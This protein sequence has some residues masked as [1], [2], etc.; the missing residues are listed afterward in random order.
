M[1]IY[2][3]QMCYYR[4]NLLSEATHA[5]YVTEY[6]EIMFPFISLSTH[7]EKLYI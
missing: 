3:K 2:N 7:I 4:E 5:A 6:T 1:F